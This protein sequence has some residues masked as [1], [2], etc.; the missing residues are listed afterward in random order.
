[1][2]NAS[3]V[4]HGVRLPS[5]VDTPAP[6][7]KFLFLSLPWQFGFLR[8]PRLTPS[9]SK[10]GTRYDAAI[11]RGCT[12]IVAASL[13][14]D[15]LFSASRSHSSSSHPHLPPSSTPVDQSSFIVGG[16]RTTVENT[17]ASVT[18]NAIVCWNLD[19]RTILE[20]PSGR[21][22]PI[23]LGRRIIISIIPGPHDPRIN[24]YPPDDRGIGV[25]REGR[26]VLH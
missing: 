6:G 14:G 3:P 4:D 12:S 19:T 5:I 22:C 15:S 26:R 8:V 9:P 20:P 1:M 18:E 24:T 25:E 11:F 21:L 17:D 13:L 7:R 2:I 10:A 23:S 16:T